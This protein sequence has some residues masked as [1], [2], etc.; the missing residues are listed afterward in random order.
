M[1]SEK[2]VGVIRRVWDETP[3]L[4]GV[5]LEVPE[6]VAAQYTTPGQ[7]VVLR[8][9]EKDQIYIAI[10]SQ[11]GEKAAL[12]LLLGEGAA[13]KLDLQVGAKIEM[14][15]P[16][17]RGFPVDKAL[18]KDVLLFA[19]GSA[20]A[21]IRPLVQL[22]RKNRSD[23]GRVTLYIGAHT[24][25]DFPYRAEYDGWKR[26]RIDVVKAVSKPWVQ[27]L[28]QKDAPSVDQSVAYVCGMKAM[29]EQVTEVLV[30]AGVPAE[31]IGRNW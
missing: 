14:N 30:A 16:T 19:V 17:G 12:E 23:Y 4:K 18:G 7:I 9:N 28:F 29:M 20:L 21:P 15:P 5:V 2:V 31:N 27:E 6:A 1:A 11:V 24:E 13:A 8:P 22:I 26:D 25:E 10:A 3:K